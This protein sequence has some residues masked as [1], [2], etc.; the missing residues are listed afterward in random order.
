M[1]ECVTTHPQAS[2][3]LTVH[4]IMVSNKFLCVSPEQGKNPKWLLLC[5]KIQDGCRCVAHG[6]V[7]VDWHKKTGML[8]TCTHRLP[9]CQK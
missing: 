2:N 8:V 4:G 7:L 9:P 3:K 1:L 5:C 6:T